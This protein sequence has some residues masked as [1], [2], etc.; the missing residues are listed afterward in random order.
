[1]MFPILIAVSVAPGSYWFA[2]SARPAEATST[3]ADAAARQN[4]GRIVLV[5]VLRL[6]GRRLRR[7][8]GRTRFLRSSFNVCCEVLLYYRPRIPRPRP[9]HRLSRLLS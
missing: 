7:P 4:A 1:M 2:A 6:Q 8:F 5:L 9:S 3:T